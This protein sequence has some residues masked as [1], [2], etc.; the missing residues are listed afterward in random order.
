MSGQF[1]GDLEL[2]KPDFNLEVG[3]SSHAQQTAEIMK[4]F[5]PVMLQERPAGVMVVGDVNSTL[6]CALVAV[7][8]GSQVVHVEAG[9]RSHDRSMPEEINRL[10]ADAVSDLLLVTE[11]SGRQNLLAEGVAPERIH[12]VGNL[13]VDSL[14]YN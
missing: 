6:A 2:P 1:F 5:E 3:S 9:L 8:L 14:R 12:V 13:M 7:K 11:K 4:R 10:V